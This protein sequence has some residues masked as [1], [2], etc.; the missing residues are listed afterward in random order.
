MSS[1]AVANDCV[2]F[3]V[4]IIH[5]VCVGQQEVGG[6][7]WSVWWE[8]ARLSMTRE[9]EANVVESVGKQGN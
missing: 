8:M 5:D 6:V 2:A 1:I 3:L 4:E 7:K 9:I